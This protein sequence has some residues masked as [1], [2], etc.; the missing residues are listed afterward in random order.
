MKNGSAARKPSVTPMVIGVKV[1]ALGHLLANHTLADLLL[2]PQMGELALGVGVL[3]E[4][5]DAA[6]FAVEPV[7]VRPRF[8]VPLPHEID[9]VIARGVPAI[10]RDEQSARLVDRG[11]PF[12]F[13]KEFHRCPPC[14]GEPR[15]RPR[16]RAA[17]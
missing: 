13:V 11:Q 15:G 1:W 14:V 7:D 2:F 5:H 10:G 17:L 16:R 3:G 6:G 9:Q 12:V 4:Q 8:A